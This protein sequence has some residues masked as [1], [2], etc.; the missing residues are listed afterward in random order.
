MISRESL[1]AQIVA[2]EARQT[3]IFKQLMAKFRTP[4]IDA[5]DRAAAAQARIGIDDA[6]LLRI[7]HE[8]SAIDARITQLRAAIDLL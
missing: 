7:H 2:L 6:R 8:T 1:E 4:A 3:A 5:T